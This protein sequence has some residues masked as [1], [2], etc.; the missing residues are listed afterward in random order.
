MSAAV[1]Y[2]GIAILVGALTV[3]VT[4]IGGFVLTAIA[5][6]RQGQMQQAGVARDKTLAEVHN[7]VNGQ[8]KK[9]E[10]LSFQAGVA[11]GGKDER[12]NPTVAEHRVDEDPKH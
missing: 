10:E 1:D 5:V 9:L 6:V 3:S 8:S 4:S 7:L 11:Q 2:Q 12:A